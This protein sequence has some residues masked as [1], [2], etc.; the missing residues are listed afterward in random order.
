M[1]CNLSKHFIRFLNSCKLILTEMN[2]SSLANSMQI[3]R[4]LCRQL[5]STIIRGYEVIAYL[6]FYSYLQILHNFAYTRC[7][8]VYISCT[9]F[10]V[11]VQAY[12]TEGCSG[13]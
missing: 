9:Y 6:L 2:E 7:A 13:S 10:Q 11:H 1:K 3:A 8:V 4:N 5:F 12:T